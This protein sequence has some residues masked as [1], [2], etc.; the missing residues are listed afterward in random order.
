MFL[1]ARLVKEEWLKL[2]DLSGL[3]QSKLAKINALAR[4]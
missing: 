2:E 4:M 3:D 1:F